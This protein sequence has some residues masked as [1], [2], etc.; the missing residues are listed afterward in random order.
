MNAE[1]RGAPI[2]RAVGLVVNQRKPRAVEDADRAQAFLR[3]R[4]VGVR[5]PN[6]EPDEKRPHAPLD[7]ASLNGSDLLVVLGGDG[8]LLAASRY[9]APRGIPMLS[10][11]Y[12]G[13]GFLAEVEPEELEWA[14]DRALAGRYALDPRMML[15]TQLARRGEVI[16][17]STALNDVTLTRGALSRVVRVRTEAGGGYLS[18]YSADG[19]IVSTPTGSTAYSLSAGGPLVHPGVKVLLITPI[20]P[21]SLN[22]RSL[23]LADHERVTLTLESADEAMLTSDGQ[24]GQPLE[25]GD[26]VHISRAA[27]TA[28]LVSLR[29]SSFYDRLQNR[30]RWADRFAE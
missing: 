16:H 6:G 23:A 3:S 13:F 30:L 24:V 29:P 27:M 20:C 22:A 4:G 14:L 9:A 18:T 17:T 19:V 11:R 5:C 28:D 2:P 8:T 10:I 25:T 1:R 21:H 12:G 7:E 15:S 26:E